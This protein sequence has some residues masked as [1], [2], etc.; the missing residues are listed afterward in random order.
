MRKAPLYDEAIGIEGIA[1]CWPPSDCDELPARIEPGGEAR[2]WRRNEVEGREDLA[3]ASAVGAL[4]GQARDGQ[5][6][7]RGRCERS[8]RA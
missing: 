6:A 1:G 2:W 5:G 3:F 4:V 7:T 8:E